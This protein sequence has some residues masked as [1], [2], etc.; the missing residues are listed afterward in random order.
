[1]FSGKW[2]SVKK[3]AIFFEISWSFNLP[4]ALYDISLPASHTSLQPSEAIFD[5]GTTGTTIRPFLTASEKVIQ[6]RFFFWHSD[7]YPKKGP[8]FRI[9]IVLIWKTKKK[10][11]LRNFFFRITFSDNDKERPYMGTSV[12]RHCDMQHNVV[13]RTAWI[14]H[15]YKSWSIRWYWTG[16][17]RCQSSDINRICIRYPPAR[18][19]V[20]IQARK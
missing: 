14:T 4:N 1:M 11:F 19:H 17:F 12:D 6:N 20:G 7:F 10:Y 15:R 13:Q 8:F 5:T 2:R 18:T 16:I 9:E 3:I